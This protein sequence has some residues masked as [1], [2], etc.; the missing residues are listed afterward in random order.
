[1][2]SF[3]GKTNR[4]EEEEEEEEGKEKKKKKKEKEEAKLKVWIFGVLYGNYKFCMG[5][6]IWTMVGIYMVFK[7][8]VLLGFHPNPRFLESRVGKTL[9]GTR[10]VW[11]PPFEV[12]FMV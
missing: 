12:R 9:N 11:N 5:L 2:V 1:M 8:R 7:P 6:C 3:W 10:R 4:G